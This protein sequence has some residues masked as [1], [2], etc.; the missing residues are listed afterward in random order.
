[1]YLY[2]CLRMFIAGEALKGG[3]PGLIFMLWFSKDKNTT[4]SED[5][6]ICTVRPMCTA[7]TLVSIYRSQAISSLGPI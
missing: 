2:W 4:L 3:R 7:T 1:M 5:I 6:A